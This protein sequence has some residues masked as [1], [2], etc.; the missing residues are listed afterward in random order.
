MVF[1]KSFH[2]YLANTLFILLFSIVK[3]IF[4]FLIMN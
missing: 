1:T 3:P 2:I 4:A